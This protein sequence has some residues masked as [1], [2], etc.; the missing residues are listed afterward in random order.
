MKLNSPSPSR[1]LLATSSSFLSYAAAVVVASTLWAAAAAANDHQRQ[2]GANPPR[3]ADAREAARFSSLPPTV[4]AP[5]GR[6]HGVERVAREAMMLSDGDGDDD[7]GEVSCGV[8]ALHCR[9]RRRRGG[10]Y[11]RDGGGGEDLAAARDD[12]GH[13]ADGE[14]AVMVGIGA[15]SPYL[16]RDEYFHS[17]EQRDEETYLPL[18]IDDVGIDAAPLSILSPTLVAGAGGKAV[19]S[20]ILLRRATEAALSTYPSE[21]GGVD[22]FVSH[23]LEGTTTVATVSGG[24]DDDCDNGSVGRMIMGGAAGV[25]AS[26]LARRVADMAQSSTQS[27]GGR[28]GRMLS[29]SL[30]VVGAR[31]PMDLNDDKIETDPDDPEDDSLILWRVDPTGQ[32]WRSDASAAGR[33]ATGA[34]AELLRRAKRW[35]HEQRRHD[36]DDEEEGYDEC[37]DDVGHDDVRAYLGSLSAEDAIELATDC[38]VDGIMKSRKRSSFANVDSSMAARLEGGLRRRVQAVVIRSCDIRQTKPCIEIV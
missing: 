33:G 5:G 3:A 36:D 24:G 19:D 23:S 32:F 25:D 2:R 27:L 10:H 35:S 29:S 11:N 15:T 9:G 31:N 20:T 30:I 17:S 1:I 37:H 12:D 16:H 7:G 38:L 34:E 4:F 6:L 8:L 21:N 14:F 22:W 28:Y 18:E 26:S 13:D